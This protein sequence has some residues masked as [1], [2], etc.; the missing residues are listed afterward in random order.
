[1]SRATTDCAGRSKS[2]KALRLLALATAILWAAAMGL[3]CGLVALVLTTSHAHAGEL[4][5]RLVTRA[6]A[7]VPPAAV[8][9][10]PVLLRAA[11]SQWGLDAPVAALAAQVHQESG[12]RGDA[13][14]AVGAQGLAQFMPATARWWCGLQRGKPNTDADAGSDAG[15]ADCL[16]TNPTWALRALVGYDKWLYDRL[17]VAGAPPDRMW[18]ALRAYNGGLGHWLAE[19]QI[20]A[21]T[22]PSGISRKEVDAACGRAKRAPQFCPES[23]GYP[24]R[25]LIALQP[26][27]AAWGP[28]IALAD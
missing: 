17:A 4:V 14:S 5:P 20:A 27:Y 16:P 2:D 15:T 24:R 13:V 8:A 21:A 12:W 10:R 1:M 7:D 18:A 23:L 11:H 3:M 28:Q 6:Q 26:R 9:L 22:S 25:I 19:R